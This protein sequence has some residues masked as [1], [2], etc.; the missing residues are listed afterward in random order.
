[1]SFCRVAEGGREDFGV[2]FVIQTGWYVCEVAP[3][4]QWEVSSKWCDFLDCRQRVQ[5]APKV[6]DKPA[7]GKALGG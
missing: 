3:L 4:G 5:C 6:H 1:M 7:Q 2:A